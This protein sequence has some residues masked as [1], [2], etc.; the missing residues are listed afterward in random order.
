MA[1]MYR[2][3]GMEAYKRDEKEDKDC[4]YPWGSEEWREWVEGFKE[5]AAGFQ[6]L[7]KKSLEN[8]DLGEFPEE[9]DLDK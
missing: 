2:R 9:G 5:A 8:V 6:Q 7:D 3:E 4:P 1:D